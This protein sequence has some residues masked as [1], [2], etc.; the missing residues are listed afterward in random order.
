MSLLAIRILINI[1]LIIALFLQ[2]IYGEDYKIDL[3]SEDSEL[4]NEDTYRTIESYTD[5]WCCPGSTEC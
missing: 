1:I 3:Y 4:D 2:T 5:F